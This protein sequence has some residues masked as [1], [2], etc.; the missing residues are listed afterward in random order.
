M[1]KLGRFPKPYPD[2]RCPLCPDHEDDVF[3]WSATLQKPICEGCDYE[4]W[5]DILC[6][7]IRPANSTVLNRLEK[8]TGL[9]FKEYRL[10]EFENTVEVLAVKLGISNK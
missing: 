5:N 8:L 6:E 10:I 7:E 4:L 3:A 1:N 2:Y 9:S